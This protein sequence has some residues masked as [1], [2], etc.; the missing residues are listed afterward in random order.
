M[1]QA[2][3]FGKYYLRKMCLGFRH[4][5]SSGLPNAPGQT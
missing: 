5:A 1:G 3:G 2:I 4:C